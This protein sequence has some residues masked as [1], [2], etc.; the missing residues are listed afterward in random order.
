MLRIQ[1][2][3]EEKGLTQN[4]IAKAIGTSRTNIGRWEKGLNEPSY[5]FVV[6]LSNYFNV[7]IDY[8]VGKEDAVQGSTYESQ[9]VLSEKEKELIR[10]YRSLS[11]NGKNTL[12]GSAHNI[13]RFDPQVSA[14]K[15]A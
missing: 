2:L 4:D 3:R 7:S 13:E 8:L 12:L 5:S 1:E 11:D 14:A 15:K 10:V 9:T 6:S